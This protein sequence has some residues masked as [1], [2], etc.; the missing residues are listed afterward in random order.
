MRKSLPKMGQD[1]ERLDAV[2]T[3]M[4]EGDI[5]WRQGRTP[6]YVYYADERVYEVSKKAFVKFFSENAI[7]G[8][9]AFFSIKRMEDEVV[10][11]GLGLLQA[12][13]E[14]CG[15]MTSGGTESI[16]LAVKT[17]RDWTRDHRPRV[18]KP[19]IVAPYSAH[20]AFDKSAR[21]MDLEVRRVPAR[22]NFRADIEAM[23]AAIDDQTMMIVGS[24]P[25][26]PYGVFD[27]MADMGRLAEER[28]IWLH[29]DAC[30]GGF[31]AP[32]ARKLGYPIPDFDFSIPGVR[33]MSADLHKFGYSPKPAST[34]FYR[35]P[36]YH[37]YQV[38]EF[39]N[40]PRG[41]F[42]API[43]T[44]TRPGGAVAAAWA[45]MHHLGE[46]GYLKLTE[47]VMTMTRDY[48]AGVNSID[49]LSI[50]GQPDL[51]II[52]FGSRKFDI[53][54]AAGRL[55]ARGWLVALNREPKA[56]HLNLSLNHEAAREDYL[57]DLS[58]AVAETIESG[59]SAGEIKAT[60]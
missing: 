59:D 16:F 29:V 42:T 54:A 49:G 6:L 40:W 25:C 14:G 3:K 22:E 35:H 45:V 31:I 43:F 26:F 21:I 36:D 4:A 60:Y 11:M 56:I 46:K 2:M 58:A 23:A 50:L 8:K 53:Y 37:R 55:T 10:E 28:G 52:L 1:W 57:A 5:S 19:N 44:G 32:F 48:M 20:P 30:V 27:P 51:S 17:C 7:G 24:A 38:F 47:R 18:L 13:E 41:L 12:P 33:S 9:S 34:V 39:D 15:N